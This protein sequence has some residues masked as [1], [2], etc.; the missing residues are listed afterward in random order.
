MDI[1]SIIMLLGKLASQYQIDI[2]G[3]THQGGWGLLQLSCPSK[4]NLAL[5]I[6]EAKEF[7]PHYFIE[8]ENIIPH[9]IT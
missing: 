6:K 5:F 2:R 1:D 4:E 8:G 3:S 7:F 9:I